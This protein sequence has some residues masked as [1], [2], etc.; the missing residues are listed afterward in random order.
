M[1]GK[2]ENFVLDET[3][4][5]VAVFVNP[6]IYPLPAVFSA[7]YSMMD[8][9]YAVIDGDREKRVVVRLWPKGTQGLKEIALEFNQELLNYAV[10]L[11]QAK[12]TEP[13]RQ[14]LAKRA[15]LAHSMAE[16]SAGLFVD[17]PMGIARPWQEQKGKKS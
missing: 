4:K 5:N 15:F 3:E 2:A 16:E 14:A 13:V 9:A 1:K 6:K 12:K 17:D 8:R 7:A 11:A 10:C